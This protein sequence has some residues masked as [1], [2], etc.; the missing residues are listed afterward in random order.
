[1]SFDRDANFQERVDKMC[2]LGVLAGYD[3][4]ATEEII[5]AM[6]GAGLSLW[7]VAPPGFKPWPLMPLKELRRQI[8]DAEKRLEMLERL[9]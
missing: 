5:K 6:D 3:R 1:M 2:K 8:G 9:G 4:T 7:L